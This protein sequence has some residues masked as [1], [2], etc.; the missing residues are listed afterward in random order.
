MIQSTCVSMCVF[1]DYQCWT[2]WGDWRV[3][4]GARCWRAR[5]R[6]L[7]RNVGLS[8]EAH[9]ALACTR[10]GT[11]MFFSLLVLQSPIK[12]SECETELYRCYGLQS[13]ET[14]HFLNVNLFHLYGEHIIYVFLFLFYI[15]SIESFQHCETMKSSGTCN[16]CFPI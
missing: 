6:S 12:T 15:S 1:Y 7:E 14:T 10:R 4:Y 3:S 2:Q 8:T 11:S 16:C 13:K 9:H 5:T